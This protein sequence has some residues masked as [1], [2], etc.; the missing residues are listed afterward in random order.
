MARRGWRSGTRS[1]ATWVAWAWISSM[2]ASSSF[3]LGSSYP[4]VAASQHQIDA[5][6]E[7]NR[8]VFVNDREGFLFA[9]DPIS[10]V[11][12]YKVGSVISV[13]V[14]VLRGGALME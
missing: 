4:V 13:R 9:K 6:S 14:R 7:R 3:P 11:A 2:A 12:M 1:F 10:D 8:D 5:I